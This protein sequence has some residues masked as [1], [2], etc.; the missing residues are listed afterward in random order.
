MPKPELIETAMS[1]SLVP[2]ENFE[3]DWSTFGPDDFEF[4]SIL[5]GFGFLYWLPQRTS[6]GV[7]PKPPLVDGFRFSHPRTGRSLLCLVMLDRDIRHISI[8]LAGKKAGREESIVEWEDFLGFS[9]VH[10]E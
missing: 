7:T 10:G 8:Q 9:D 1:P 3:G 4:G 2:F 5:R 6:P